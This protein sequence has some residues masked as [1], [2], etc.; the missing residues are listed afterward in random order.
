MQLEFGATKLKTGSFGAAE[1]RTGNV[2]TDAA[3][4]RY[5]IFFGE[6]DW[7]RMEN[8]SDY[9]EFASKTGIIRVMCER[10]MALIPDPKNISPKHLKLFGKA[11]E[12]ISEDS[13]QNRRS[14]SP[15]IGRVYHTYIHQMASALDFPSTAVFLRCLLYLIQSGKL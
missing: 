8:L 4:K 13:F 7:K 15:D 9:Y 2:M 11:Y 12:V 3:P 10:S 5:Q 1:N 14:I 6:E